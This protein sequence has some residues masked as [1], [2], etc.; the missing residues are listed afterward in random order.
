MPPEHTLRVLVD[1]TSIP[2]SQGGVAR[3]IFGM[4]EGFDRLHLEL[5]VVCRPDSAETMRR[6]VPWATIRVTSRL[7][8]VRALRMVW[9]Q[10]RL[11]AIARRE[12]ID[13]I[14]S[15]HYSYPLLSR[16]R[17]VVTLHDATFVT[18]PDVHTT[19]KR[20][21]FRTWM[22]LSWRS[23][24]VVMTPSQSTADELVR[25]MGARKGAVQVAYL[26]VDGSVF[27]P[28][29]PDE[30]AAFRA[31]HG[32]G[33]FDLW[34]AFLGT[35]EPR[36]NVGVLLEAYLSLRATQGSE[37][38][39]L[40]IAGGRGWDRTTLA[41]L[42]GL[43]PADG[44]SVLGYIPTEELAALLGG[45]VAVIYP[46]Q[47]EGFG[48]PVAEA[49]S[50]GATVITTPQLATAEVGGDAVVYATPD[51]RSLEAGMLSVLRND[52]ERTDRSAR[53]I[54]RAAAFDWK[55]TAFAHLVAYHGSDPTTSQ[56][57]V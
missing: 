45:S 20:F 39:R 42:D 43:G 52:H 53:A 12:R 2:A 3:Y 24:D 57:T 50:C 55:S 51:A 56:V 30:L 47:A 19:L 4:L 16:R 10:F 27:H 32:L 1:A 8:N 13:V 36:K 54:E 34:Y 29:A 15:P 26:G 22:R 49:M 37:T 9:E 17:R 11:P 5:V 7:Q 23:A 21:Y 25:V 46:S 35:I 14:H 44:V 41:R 48:L 18:H 33:E 40:L 6:I 38:P 28:P 31:A